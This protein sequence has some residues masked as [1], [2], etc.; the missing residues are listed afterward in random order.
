MPV[1][2]AKQARSVAGV[3]VA[4]GSQVFVVAAG[5]GGAGTDAAFG[6]HDCPVKFETEF[7]HGIGFV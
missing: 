5:K 6:R 1:C 2:V 3:E 4:D 7:S